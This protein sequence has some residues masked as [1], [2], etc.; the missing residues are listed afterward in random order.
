ML[1]DSMKPLSG[2]TVALV[3]MLY[4]LAVLITSLTELPWESVC[5]Q[6][7]IAGAAGSVRN[8]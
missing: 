6:C 4:R 2:P 3:L 5:Y 8:A 7:V 1:C